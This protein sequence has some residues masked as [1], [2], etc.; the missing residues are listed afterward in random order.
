M[1]AVAI[2]QPASPKSS[3]EEWG[4]NPFVIERGQVIEDASGPALS[5]IMWDPANP[6]AIINGQLLGVGDHVQQWQITEITQEH[7]VVSDGEKTQ[8]LSVQ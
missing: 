8:T 4:E 3:F 6:V 2:A 1:S 5:G 7:V